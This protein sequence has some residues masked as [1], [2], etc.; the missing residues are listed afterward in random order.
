MGPFIFGVNLLSLW[1][2]CDRE[3]A[4]LMTV[5]H[6][7]D[8]LPHVEGQG[9]GELA[10]GD[11][12]LAHSVDDIFQSVQ[13]Q[14]LA[15]HRRRRLIEEP[16][17]RMIIYKRRLVLRRH[18]QRADN[19][20]RRFLIRALGADQGVALA[21]LIAAAADEDQDPVPCCSIFHQGLARAL[22]HFRFGHEIAVD[23]LDP[24]LRALLDPAPG[25]STRDRLSPA[26]N[27]VD[28]FNVQ[29]EILLLS[30]VGAVQDLI[31][32]R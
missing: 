29:Q 4:Y 26:R 17:I 8:G 7:L 23:A 31:S 2:A 1:D 28:R 16:E 14:D 13:I 15:A 11:V 5:F 19:G 9:A 3:S 22:D 21:N 24:E 30:I 20:P 25:N 12:I 18:G 27:V 32:G 6:D 10:E